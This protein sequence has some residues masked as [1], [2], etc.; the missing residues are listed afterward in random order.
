MQAYLTHNL[1]ADDIFLVEA[2][3]HHFIPSNANTGSQSWNAWRLKFELSAI[4]LVAK[5]N[6][7]STENR[8]SSSTETKESI[9][10]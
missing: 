5:A 2:H 8:L 9:V 4:L 7:M 1:N 3:I 10:I 6:T